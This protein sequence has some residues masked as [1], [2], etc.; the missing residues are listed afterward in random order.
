MA[1]SISKIWA[2][3]QQ[4]TLS[5]RIITPVLLPQPPAFVVKVALITMALMLREYKYRSRST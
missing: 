4:L 1:P 3:L 2:I 5:F